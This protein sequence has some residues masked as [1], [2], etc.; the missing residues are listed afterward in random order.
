MV[1]PELRPCPHIKQMACAASDGTA[2]RHPEKWAQG[3][4]TSLRSEV[5]LTSRADESDILL[6]RRIS[7]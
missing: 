6:G 3:T 4:S 2:W 1:V 5:T 7:K